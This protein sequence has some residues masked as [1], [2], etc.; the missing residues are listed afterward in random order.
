MHAGS[1]YTFRG[2]V[3]SEWWRH[4]DGNSEEIGSNVKCDCK[5]LT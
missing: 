4:M 1:R 2:T 5:L 3:D